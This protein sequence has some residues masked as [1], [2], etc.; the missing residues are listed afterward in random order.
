MKHILYFT[1]ALFIAKQ[2][3][4]SQMDET[5]RVSLNDADAWSRIEH[6][7]LSYN[8]KPAYVLLDFIAEEYRQESMPHVTGKDRQLLLQRKKNQH[9]PNSALVHA[10]HLEREK[11]GRKDDKYLFTGITDLE[12]VQPILD[13]FFRVKLPIAGMYSLPLLT[14]QLL[15]YM[16]HNE[17][18]LLIVLQPNTNNQ[19]KRMFRQLF[20]VNGRLVIS[21]VNT[22][23]FTNIEQIPEFLQ[24]EQNR[25]RYFLTNNRH[26]SNEQVMDSIFIMP[27]Q[28]MQQVE[29]QGTFPELTQN[30]FAD[31][32]DLLRQ[33]GLNNFSKPPSLAD[34]ACY[35]LGNHSTIKP[36]FSGD[37]QSFY[38]RHYQLNNSLIIASVLSAVL[39]ISLAGFFYQQGQT[40][41][42][43]SR[44]L[45]QQLDAHQETFKQLDAA[46]TYSQIEA[47]RM[48]EAVEMVKRIQ[49]VNHSPE[50]IFNLISQALNHTSELVLNKIVWSPSDNA[51]QST[52][53][54]TEIN[55]A[56]LERRP[57]AIRIEGQVQANSMN[58][59]EANQ[60]VQRF[61]SHLNLLQEIQQTVAEK[62]PYDVDS[63]L[64]ISG[65]AGLHAI[66]KDEPTFI[67]LITLKG[68]QDA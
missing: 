59:D 41:F 25:M 51:Q 35:Y 23:P 61:I 58:Y 11:R 36:H 18:V 66:Q 19:Q 39:S 57:L 55:H 8:S 14:E 34:I 9:F 1:D 40:S 65:S 48:Q 47:E 5:F 56:V 64:N 45:T 53:R 21:R 16:P 46:T 33:T 7:L 60:T 54:M 28:I 50:K 17:N 29:L 26:I 68:Y 2:V 62:M 38:N 15:N 32:G 24:R 31:P 13:L 49:L 10:R 20:F 67:L 3:T 12:D 22:C 63:T 44:Q 52:S 37:K 42:E 30:F 6:Y 43:L 27:P 4:S